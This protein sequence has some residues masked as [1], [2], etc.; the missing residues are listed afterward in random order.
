MLAHA[1]VLGYVFNPLTVYWCRDHS[2]LR[3]VIA[4][5]HNTYGGRHRYLVHPDDR[6]RAAVDKALYVSPFNRVEG[7][8]RLALP[9]PGQ[10]LS[11]TV[12]LH[13]HGRPPFTA[14]VRGTRRK[15]TPGA[16]LR[17]ALR[18]PLAPLVGAVRI[19]VQGIGLYLRGLPV[20]PD[21]HQAPTPTGT[22]P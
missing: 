11:L 20:Q 9:E 19:R 1:R 15:A 18:H 6:G 2:G 4:E 16:L 7:H 22:R 8:Y 12:A 17:M 10:R 3:A 14:T 13:R 5:V 21:E